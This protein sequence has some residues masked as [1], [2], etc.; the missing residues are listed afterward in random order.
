MWRWCL[1]A[2]LALGCRGAAY[3][4]ASRLDTARAYRTFLAAHPDDPDTGAAQERLE[5][6]ELEEA[7]RVHTL[8]AYKR[9]LEEFPDSSRAG[10]ARALLEGLRFNLAVADGGAPAWRAFLREHPEGAH[11]AEAEERLARLEAEAPPGTDGPDQQAAAVARPPGQAAAPEAAQRLDDL[12]FARVDGAQAALDYLDR[13]AA[14]RHRDEARLRLLSLELDS[15]LLEGRLVEA[16][17]LVHRSP[18]GAGLG[19]VEL[20]FRRAE[21]WAALATS[22]DPRVR[23]AL[24]AT[25]LRPLEALT[26]ALRAADPL[27]RWQAAEE[28]GFSGSPSALAPLL[29]ALRSGRSPLLRWRCLEAALRLLDSLPR[30]VAEYEVATRLRGLTG[31]SPDAPLALTEAV[32]Q[33]WLWGPQRAAAAYQRAFDPSAPDPVVLRRW[34]LLRQARGQHF[35]AAVAARQLA[36]A[37]AAESELAGAPEPATALAVAR[38]QCA[39]LD[40]ARFATQVLEAAAAQPTEFPQDVAGFLASAAA[41]RRLI[42]ARLRDAEL[43]LL[44]ADAGARPCADEGVHQRLQ[45]GVERRL[46][47][48]AALRLRPAR[49]LPT[50]LQGLVERDPSP[51]VRQILR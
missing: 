5:A 39:A 3:S 24:P 29:E 16:R 50:L 38:A 36:L 35:S 28:L 6:L 15:L 25:S 44:T 23:A 18:L 34:T 43:L 41:Q 26:A 27:D 48:L 1:I 2:L 33:D 22:P 40:A 20:R 7:Q 21:A 49:E 37:A 14:G 30:P 10:T 45:A 4:E 32:L 31:Q 19:D 11:R 51:E 42:E 8:V 13:F 9:F 47:A 46:A 17:T 12:A